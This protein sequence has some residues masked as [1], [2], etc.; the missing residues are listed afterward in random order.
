MSSH[1][2]PSSGLSVKAWRWSQTQLPHLLHTDPHH[3]HYKGYKAV[4]AEIIFLLN[5]CQYCLH[6]FLVKIALEYRGDS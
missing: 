1:R 3:Q 6:G 2:E 5:Y 4:R